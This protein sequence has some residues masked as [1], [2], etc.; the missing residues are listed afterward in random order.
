VS[1]VSHELRTPLTS[2]RMFID[3]LALGR[4]QDEKE[5]R[6][7]LGMLSRE[8]ERLSAL[9][10]RGLDWSRIE[11]GR[12]EDHRGAW[13]VR[14]LLD[15]SMEALRAQHFNQPSRVE[16]QVEENLPRVD[17]DRD[18]LAGA[19]LNLLQN[20]YKYSGEDQR[21]SL[22]ALREAKGVAIEVED[23]GVGIAP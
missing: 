9:I 7:I 13:D 21:I 11:S 8:T 3:T 4:V 16:V 23:R 1:L 12:K 14:E 17:V 6:E 18:A 19:L 10:E 2:I 5:V 20:A 22:R 15:A